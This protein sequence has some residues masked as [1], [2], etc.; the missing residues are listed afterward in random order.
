MCQSTTPRKIKN[1]KH[2]EINH[3]IVLERV[4]AGNRRHVQMSITGTVYKEGAGCRETSRDDVAATAS[5]HHPH[6]RG[7]G[8]WN[9]VRVLEKRLP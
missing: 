5:Y 8:F 7:T 9:P 2:V 1:K 3:W 4:S 6:M